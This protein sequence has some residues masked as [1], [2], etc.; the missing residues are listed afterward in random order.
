MILRLIWY[1]LIGFILYSFIKYISRLL[2]KPKQ[3]QKDSSIKR[4]VIDVDYEEIESKPNQD[5]DT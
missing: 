5:K 4:E 1:L 3:N 2:M